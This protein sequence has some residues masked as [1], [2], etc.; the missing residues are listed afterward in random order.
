MN[1]YE[2][3]SAIKD[4]NEKRKLSTI[5]TPTP[6]ANTADVYIQTRSIERLDLLAYK[7]YNDQS[8]WYIIAAANGLG[9]GSLYVPAN[10]RLR[11]PSKDTI[12]Q[13]TEQTNK[14]R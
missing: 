11:I 9:K 12:Q 8:L 2:T 1:R 7:F 5:I 4:S 13:Q 6:E 3:A 14:T 10:S